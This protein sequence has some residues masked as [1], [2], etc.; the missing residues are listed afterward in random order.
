MQF[1]YGTFSVWFVLTF[2]TFEFFCV[3][4]KAIGLGLCWCDVCLCGCDLGLY[5]CDLGLCGCDFGRLYG[6]DLGLCGGDLGL[7]GCDG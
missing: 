7:C 6:R 5:G 3:Q 2:T 1:T 4:I